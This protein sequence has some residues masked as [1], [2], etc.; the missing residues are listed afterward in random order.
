[1]SQDAGDYRDAGCAVARRAFAIYSDSLESKG[2]TSWCHRTFEANQDN[3]LP[4][5]KP[6]SQRKLLR[7]PWGELSPGIAI[8]VILANVGIQSDQCSLTKCVQKRQ[9]DSLLL[10]TRGRSVDSAN[11]DK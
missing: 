10:D 8:D 7:N 6:E 1:M 3:C 4:A 5:A 2:V 11:F 9:S